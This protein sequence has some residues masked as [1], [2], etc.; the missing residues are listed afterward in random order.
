MTHLKLNPQDVKKI[1]KEQRDF[2]NSGKTKDIAFRLQQLRKLREG[3]E[4]YEGKITEALKKDLG[5]HPFESY[6]TEIGFVL[7]SITYIMKNLRKWA[8][9][10]RVKTPLALFPSKSTIVYE[11]YGTVLIIAP[12]NYPF[13]LVIEPLIGAMAAGNC[14]VLK[15]SRD[16]PN[17]SNVIKEMIESIFD[18]SYIRVVEGG[19]ETNTS[20]INAPF[21]YI[22]FTGSKT[23]GRVVME[24]AS[25]NLVPVTLELGGKSP[26]IVDRTADI[27]VAAKR[28]IWG[29]TLNAGQTC[30][31]PDYI[32]I[33][34]SKKIEFIK[35]LVESIEE[36][37]GNDPLNNPE[38]PKIINRKHFERILSYI[39]K[40]EVLYGGGWDEEKNKIAPV[41]IDA[42]WKS[43]SM[44][45]EIFGPVLPIISFNS[46]EEIPEI[47]R[48]KPQ[49][50]AL[51]LF[52]ESKR[53]ENFIIN[54]VSFG[55]GAVNDVVIQ[56]STSYLPFG[57]IGNSGLGTYH[58][59]ESFETFSHKKS[60][61]KKSNLLDIPLRYPPFKDN[62][63]LLKKIL[64]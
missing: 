61:L 39:E 62:L 37:Y 19:R 50:L 6:T 22:F 36:F 51:Y 34:E 31:A 17:V 12:F 58:G 42:D 16:T 49:P 2:F 21:D 44:E 59:K 18:R 46:I 35:Y 52:T 10:K 60:I 45:E 26:A 55:G 30:V 47:L 4:R 33:Q 5:K 32:L 14:A 48:E 20:L 64:K 13:Q 40:D 1:L 27:K 24:A 53:V 28:I 38:Y 57:G 15:T 25:K 56:V 7:M 54:E 9:P 41:I 23:V 11:P 8:R 29:K 3:I 63:K 43:A